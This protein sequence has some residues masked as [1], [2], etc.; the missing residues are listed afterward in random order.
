MVDIL[1]H[2]R[3]IGSRAASDSPSAAMSIV[4]N[5]DKENI[6]VTV[7][8][9]TP[10]SEKVEADEDVISVDEAMRAADAVTRKRKLPTFKEIV[11][12]ADEKT[13][14]KLMPI[15]SWDTLVEKEVYLIN[16]VHEMEITLKNGAKKTTKYIYIED[17]DEN[18][19]NVWISEL[20]AE[21]LRDY[22]VSDK[23]ICL[24]PLGKKKSS[25]SGYDYN[26][27]VIVKDDTMNEMH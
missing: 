3:I 11:T 9:D 24:I 8:L 13:K 16:S 1:L 19:M 6:G 18:C 17:D 20:I 12:K 15:M 14:R 7:L 5:N 21:N 25:T 22:E 2:L 27:F 10:K 4:Q 26:D 23:N